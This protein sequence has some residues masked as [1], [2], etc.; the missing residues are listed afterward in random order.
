[1]IGQDL[2]GLAELAS[3]SFLSVFAVFLRIGAAMA[4]LPVIGE[5]SVPQRFRILLAIGY[6]AVVMPAV[7]LEIAAVS[8]R[9]PILF[10]FAE[11][12]TGLTIGLGLRMFIFA[13]QL[14]G[15]IAAQS[16][17]LSQVFGGT[18]PDPLPAIG[19]L[20]VVGGLAL[21][22]LFGLHVRIAEL[23]IYSYTAMPAGAFLPGESAS[24]WVV[25]RVAHMFRLAFAIAAP[26]VI[27]SL[28]YNIALGAINRAMPQLMV[29]FVG[30]PAI[31]AGGLILLF[32]AAPV[33]LQ[34]WLEAMDQFL[35]DPFRS[36]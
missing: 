1:M 22:V 18:G 34:V 12:V 20:L 9:N 7:W 33:M 14:A 4:L 13:L 8:D 32:V 21:A 15:S 30:A 29:S 10:L 23:L 5:R 11:T 36:D 6:T 28:I 27:A 31:T 35:G 16:T 19:H 17:S 2:V 24:V 26:F 25:A 3:E